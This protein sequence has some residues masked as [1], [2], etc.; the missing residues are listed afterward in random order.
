VRYTQFDYHE[1][2]ANTAR[3]PEHMATYWS[4]H[5]QRP[6]RYDDLRSEPIWG[7]IADVLR[8]P[9]YVLEAGCGPAQWVGFLEELGYR[10]L[11]VDFAQPI[12][13]RSLAAKPALRLLAADLRELPFPDGMF[14]FIFSNGAVEHDVDGPAPMLREFHRVLKPHGRLMCSVPCL[15]LERHVA[16]PWLVLRDWLKRRTLLRRLAGKTAPFEFYQ[17]V[18][19]PKSYRVVLDECGWDVIDLRPYGF[20]GTRLTAAVATRLTGLSR[21]AGNHMMM[22]IC[23]KRAAQAADV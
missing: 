6:R 16:L 8:S 12:L 23:R 11:G 9:G 5:W 21:F 2:G 22:A 19:S 7:T 3:D 4:A 17:Y 10:T 13:S 14:D 15:N 20:A 1:A 18:Y